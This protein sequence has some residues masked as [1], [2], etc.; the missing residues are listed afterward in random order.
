MSSG[1]KRKRSDAPGSSKK[2]PKRYKSTAVVKRPY[3]R[4]YVPR[5]R[6]GEIKGMDTLLTLSPV[7]QTLSSNASMFVLN[8]IQPGSGSWNRI[9]RKVRNKSVRLTGMFNFVCTPATTTGNTA[10]NYVR[11]LVVWD[12]QPSSGAVPQY[13][14][15]INGTLQDGSEQNSL[16]AGVRYDNMERFSILRDCKYALN[17]Q[18]L[19]GIG[20]QMAIQ[21][22][23]AFDEY[24]KLA[25]RETVYSGQSV[26]QTIADISTGAIYVFF[27]AVT[28]GVADFVSVDS[29]SIARLRYSD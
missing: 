22:S 13:S 1:Y 28:N 10:S 15:I 12:K 7:I 18:A 29:S 16:N 17:P 25:G 3:S 11:M 5:Q 27:R 2:G 4:S 19:P 26:P 14:D 8:L 20:N 21:Q 23:M 24:I 9:G 6:M